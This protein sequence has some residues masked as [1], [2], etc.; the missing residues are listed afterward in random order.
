MVKTIHSR[1]VAFYAV[2]AFFVGLF[3]SVSVAA[4]Q[5]AR[6]PINAEAEQT[7]DATK[8]ATD[9]WKT[10]P[11]GETL[12]RDH[13]FWANRRVKVDIRETP[14]VCLY[15]AYGELDESTHGTTVAITALLK[16]D[17]PPNAGC[18]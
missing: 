10:S 7:N 3:I 2:S 13:P 4:W 14:N 16:R 5:R 12:F 9:G 6:P 8:P 11:D 15:V 17:L 1:V 18:K